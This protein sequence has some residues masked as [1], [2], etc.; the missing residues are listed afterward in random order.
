MSDS[1]LRPSVWIG[2]VVLETD[3][4]RESSA[5]MQTI[6]MRLIHERSDV[7][8]LE[9]RGGTHLVLTRSDTVVAGTAPFDLMVDD[10]HHA[11]GSF[12]SLGLAPST[13]ES[14]P[15]VGHEFFT[16]REPAGHVISVY[17]SHV[18]GRVV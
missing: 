18:G 7:A 8:V 10:L 5:F 6:G 13:I 17:S 12:T 4:V 9:L 1:D 14:I 16:I 3:R 11:H 15:S 2:H